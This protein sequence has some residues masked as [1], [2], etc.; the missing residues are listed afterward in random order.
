MAGGAI[1][2][3][4]LAARLKELGYGIERDGK[5][6]KISGVEKSIC[7]EFSKR[8]NQ[9]VKELQ[10]TGF[11]S[12]K[13]ASFAALSTRQTK[14]IENREV[15]FESWKVRAEELGLNGET[16]HV[17]LK[18]I[19]SSTSK[20]EMTEV[21]ELG[22][23]H[24]AIGERM[25]FTRNSRMLGVKNGQTGTLN[26]WGMDER[27]DLQL[28]IRTDSGRDVLVNPQKYAHLEYGYAVSVHKAQGATVDNAYVLLSEVMNDR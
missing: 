26:R 13:A 28:S 10:Q 20:P 5:S 6:F 22:E 21:T 2:R 3:A 18:A 14:Q 25:L 1:Y 9:I 11:N 27:G 19:H 23:R 16:V 12:A 15:L 24:F 4:E 17:L 8:R 7:D